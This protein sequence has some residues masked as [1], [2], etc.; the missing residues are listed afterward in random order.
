VARAADASARQPHDKLREVEAQVLAGMHR[1][2]G[3]I[4][5]QNWRK[6]ICHGDFHPNNLLVTN[7]GLV[8]IDIGGLDRIPLYKDMARFLVHLAKRGPV[9]SGRRRYGVDAALY[10]EFAVVFQMN[11]AELSQ[12][13]PFMIGFEILFRVEQKNIDD[14]RLENALHLAWSWVSDLG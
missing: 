10:E 7:D 12:F 3:Q 13:L 2:A 1:L 11:G 5:G 9:A 14:E 8:G 4:S 6:A